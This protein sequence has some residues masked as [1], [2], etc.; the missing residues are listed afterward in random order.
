M[1]HLI[2]YVVGIDTLSY[3]H[4]LTDKQARAIV[5][6]L[7]DRTKFFTEVDDYEKDSYACRSEH[8][9][10]RGIKVRV[11]RY[12]GNLWGL[13]IL[14]H[15]TLLLGDDDRSALYRP[16]KGSYNE[17]LK[18]TKAIFKELNIPFDLEDMALSRADITIN[19]IFVDS[20]YV[21][22][23]LRIIKKA[24]TLKHYS[25]DKFRESEHKAKDPKEANKHSYIQRCK[26]ASYFV[27]DKTA[28][29]HMIDKFPETLEKKHILRL[30]AQLS[31]KAMKKW[32]KS[33]ACKNH[34]QVLHQ[35]VKNGR[36]IHRWYLKRMGLLLGEHM[37]YEDAVER[38]N[39]VKGEK[40]RRHML[41]IM[42]ALGY[43][44]A[45]LSNVLD[46]LKLKPNAASKALRMFSELG[47]S[48]ITVP[49]A[50]DA[51]LPGMADLRIFV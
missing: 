23:Y 30:E 10:E 49:N 13:Y 6:E 28:Q 27:Y 11:A 24:K 37:R 50:E 40:T 39:T 14:V 17:L 34:Y 51:S 42:E 36:D 41:A 32:C 5:R 19:L 16:K 26:S 18:Q 7:S 4:V 12:K 1:K 46:K 48:P 43:N 20:E 25:L 3:Y 47:I 31:G 9:A 44:N 21:D 8:Y 45:N 33:K 29:L 22:R 15:P 35:L 2:N 38:V